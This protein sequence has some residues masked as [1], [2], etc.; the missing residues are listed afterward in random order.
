[1]NVVSDG[2]R[3]VVVTPFYGGADRGPA[4]LA[5]WLARELG[6]GQEV[7]VATTTAR[8]RTWVPQWPAGEAIEDGVRVVRYDVD[9]ATG[10]GVE[11]YAR[12]VLLRQASVAEHFEFLRREGPIV[13]ALVSF[14]EGQARRGARLVFCSYRTAM[15][16]GLHAA[17]ARSVLWPL[18]DAASDRE[19]EAY[20]P[21]L[22]LAG[23]LAFMSD[24]EAERLER[25]L[26]IGGG[27]VV[28]FPVTDLPPADAAAFREQR[29]IAGPLLL[30]AGDVS[31][32]EDCHELFANWSALRDRPQ[33]TLKVLALSG[34]ILMAFPRR[35][36]VIELGRLGAGERASALAAADL[37][38]TASREDTVGA[39]IRDAWQLGTPAL[40]PR[41]NAAL[42]A[43]VRR[44]GGGIVYGD[45]EGF[46]RG[47]NELIEDGRGR[48]ACGREWVRAHGDRCAVAERVR[49]VLERTR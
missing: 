9:A 17:P 14:V 12:K 21:V 26:G 42:A 44:A 43:L 13:H 28:G 7:V 27:E 47:V 25:D 36:D 39:V 10:P 1:M 45:T 41:A 16:L 19:L 24:D 2:G 4:A 35:P 22:D 11:S 32:T 23:V 33:M 46:I 37:V 38:V 29:G 18:L 34:E 40:V 8:D 20:R 30:Y 31:E 3:I 6:R 15:A 49:R 48:G 5:A